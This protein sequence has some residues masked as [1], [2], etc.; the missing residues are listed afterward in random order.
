MTG[1]R[2]LRE[3]FRERRSSAAIRAR[4]REGTRAL[5][6]SGIYLLAGSRGLM[7]RVII[8]TPF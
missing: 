4:P 2:A 7:R 1:A 8:K 5:I 6:R 3:I